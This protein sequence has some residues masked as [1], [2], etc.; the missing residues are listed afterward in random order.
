MHPETK[1]RRGG[2][3]NALQFR[4]SRD[5]PSF[6]ELRQ[7][8]GSERFNH[9][10]RWS[11]NRVAQLAVRSSKCS[12]TKHLIAVRPD[13]NKAN[14]PIQ[15]RWLAGLPRNKRGVGSGK[16]AQDAAIGFDR[17]VV[18]A[19]DHSVLELV[20]HAAQFRIA[21]SFGREHEIDHDDLRARVGEALDQRSPDIARP[22]EPPAQGS[23]NRIVR[24]FL[25]QNLTV[26]TG[27]VDADQ[28]EV[29]IERSLAP[30]PGEPVLRVALRVLVQML[31]WHEPLQ[32]DHYQSH[33]AT[34]PKH[35]CSTTAALASR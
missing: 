26:V 25:G 8:A 11:L 16:L 34:D 31:Q 23:E 9:R 17:A 35:D 1:P 22:R 13:V 12:V 14:T 5:T 30:E 21:L 10:I 19:N 33:Q 15:S 4:S 2:E 7:R 20:E 18:A 27:T 3:A 6:T 29:R 24:S 32:A 28:D